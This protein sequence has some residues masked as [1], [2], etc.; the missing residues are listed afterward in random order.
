MNKV[1][2]APSAKL[3]LEA[4][5]TYRIHVTCIVIEKTDF[6]SEA[7][8]QMLESRKRH[9]TVLTIFHAI[10]NYS[11]IAEMAETFHEVR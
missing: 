2:D 6:E 4:N 9:N 8:C 10:L 1:K 5:G 3:H 11:Y 7:T